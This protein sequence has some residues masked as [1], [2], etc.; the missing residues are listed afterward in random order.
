M[1]NNTKY[2]YYLEVYTET[3]YEPQAQYSGSASDLQTL[4]ASDAFRNLYGGTTHNF[5]V[6]ISGPRT[7]WAPDGYYG[8]FVFESYEQLAKFIQKE[9]N[10]AL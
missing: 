3:S 5:G 8:Y 9:V 1:E 4:A 2:V 6:S 7:A 10:D